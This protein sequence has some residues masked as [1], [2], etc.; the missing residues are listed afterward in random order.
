MSVLASSWTHWRN[1][2]RRADIDG[3]TLSLQPGGQIVLSTISRT[4]LARLL[5]ITAAENATLG[6]VSP[7]TH[8]Y[9]KFVRPGELRDFFAARSSDRWDRIELRGVVYDP[10]AADWR[11]MP[12]RSGLLAD[13]GQRVNYFFAALKL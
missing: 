2:P 6:F 12:R 9:R 5:T 11:L 8:T 13:A 4:P 1:S 10:I 7:G 3:R